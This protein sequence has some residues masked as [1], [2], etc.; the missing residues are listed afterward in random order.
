MSPTILEKWQV[1]AEQLTRLVESAP[2]LRGMLLG[3]IAEM[4][5]HD[6]YLNHPLI[7]KVSKKDDHDR[8]S[9]GDRSFL[10]KDQPIVVEVKSLQSNTVK[11]LEDG[12]WRGK[13]QVD[14]SDR[15]KVKLPNGEIFETTC[16]VVGGFDLLA[17]NCFAFGEEWR[18]VFA[19]NEELP[20][21]AWKGYHPR[22]RKYLLAT[23]MEVTWPPQP[24]F[25]EDPFPLLEEIV[26]ERARR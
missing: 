4:K 7:S 20:R 26:R 11:R 14:A 10:Y 12:T 15:R 23:L 3:Y 5:F 8:S 18:F 13:T 19:K 24:P 17:V 1:T 9:K 21:S 6:R 25:Y 2:S 22:Q 16:L